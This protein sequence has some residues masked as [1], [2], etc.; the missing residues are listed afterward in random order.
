MKDAESITGIGTLTCDEPTSIGSSVPKAGTPSDGNA[1]ADSKDR[2]GGVCAD[3]ST[4]V[5]LAAYDAVA[6]RAELN[7]LDEIEHP[8]GPFPTYQRHLD[9]ILSQYDTVTGAHNMGSAPLRYIL[10]ASRMDTR[11]DRLT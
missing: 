2:W 11:K 8:W 1:H 5:P 10:H 6:L 4:E 7:W 3:P 9:Y